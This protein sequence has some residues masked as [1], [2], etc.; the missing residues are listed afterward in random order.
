MSSGVSVAAMRLH[1][2]IGANP[3][4]EVRSCRVIYS[5]GCPARFGFTGVALLPSAPWQ[6]AQ[7]SL[8]MVWALR[9]RAW[10]AGPAPGPAAAGQRAGDA[11][12]AAT[13]VSSG[14]S[15]K[16]AG[17]PG[18]DPDASP[19]RCRSNGAKTTYCNGIAR[20]GQS[21]AARRERAGTASG[22]ASAAAGGVR[23]HRRRR[24]RN[25][26]RRA[27]RKSRSP[28]GRMPASRARSTRSPTGRGSR[29]PARRRAARSRSTCSACASGALL[30][31]L[32]GYGYAAVPQELKRAL[33][34]VPR[35]LS[36]DAAV[37]G[38]AGAGRRRAARAGRPRRRA[39]RGL[40]RR[41]AGRC[42]CSRPRWTSSR[43]RRSARRSGR[44]C[45]DVAAAFP[46]HAAQ[47]AVVP[48][49]ATRRIGI[50][51]AEAMLLAEWLGES[52]LR[53]RRGRRQTAPAPKK[54]P[55][56]QGEW[57]GARNTRR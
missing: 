9:G 26:R 33:A 21:R 22:E 24:R 18:G 4:L 31:D 2:R 51:E 45:A 12:P 57:R 3:R 20:P 28:A 50:E 30:A 16:A 44:S 17:D 36:R 39:A 6:A 29:S 38:R 23:A 25:C 37:A 43:R 13:C 42:S 46:A 48:F 5:A 27:R 14:D 52:E 8:T 49:S 10:P 1:D 41:A 55:R 54:R 15:S 35:A 19:A 47:V 11:R 56:G 7:T 40:S 34:G 32:P 53:C